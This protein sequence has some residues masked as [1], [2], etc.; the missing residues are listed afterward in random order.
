L[1][2]HSFI[3]GL[4]DIRLDDIKKIMSLDVL[5]ADIEES[6]NEKDREV[7]NHFFYSFDNDNLWNSLSDSDTFS[8][9][10]TLSKE[11]LDDF[12]TISKEGK[13]HQDEHL[14]AYFAEFIT[15][16]LSDAPI[17]AEMSWKD[18]LT[19]LYYLNAIS[20]TEGLVKEWFEFNLNLNNVLSA[21]VAR[22]HSV[23]VSAVV[24][25]DDEIA[26]NIKNST[27]KDFGIAAMF[28][29]LDD[30]LRISEI[31]NILEREQKTDALRWQWLEDNSAFEYFSKEKI[32][33]YLL[34]LEMLERWIQLDKTTG[35]DVFSQFVK[36]LVGS[37]EIDVE[38]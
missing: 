37:V 16:Y 36:V 4:P 20:V 29:Q 12:I 9:L 31:N 21:I 11:D 5:R 2:Y 25:G 33:S 7:L 23:D 38:Q 8:T 6:I 24:V 34:Q 22:R 18:Q 26:Q 27:S 35:Q 28:P 3:A 15:A 32:F 19:T 1:E 17:Y 10:G 30:V 13:I 14:P